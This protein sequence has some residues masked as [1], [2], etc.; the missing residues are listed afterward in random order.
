M[1]IGVGVLLPAAALGVDPG[2]TVITQVSL[3]AIEPHELGETVVPEGNDG[4]KAY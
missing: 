3:G 2:V 1:V 4:D